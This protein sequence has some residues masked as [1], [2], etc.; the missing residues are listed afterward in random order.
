MR[1]ARLVIYIWPSSRM[2]CGQNSNTDVVVGDGFRTM[3]WVIAGSSVVGVECVRCYEEGS[4]LG[5]QGR[6]GDG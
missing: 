5:D 6:L 3:R 2:R 1:G 4:M